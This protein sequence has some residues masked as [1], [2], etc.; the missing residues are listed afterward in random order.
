M[1]LR[2]YINKID[3]KLFE[4]IKHLKDLKEM[5]NSFQEKFQELLTQEKL[6]AYQIVFIRDITGLLFE[7]FDEIFY[8][9]EGEKIINKLSRL[10]LQIIGLQN[11]LGENEE[12][13]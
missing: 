8:S 11:L 3:L 5:N 4:V 10:E 7:N 2:T 13:N 1:D 9:I 6:E 12:N